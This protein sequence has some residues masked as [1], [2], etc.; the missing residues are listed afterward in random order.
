MPAQIVA[1]P[2][3]DVKALATWLGV[4]PSEGMFCWQLRVGVDVA[5][6]VLA[7]EVEELVAEL[8]DPLVVADRLC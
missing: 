2:L 3:A 6:D 1:I 4:G 8:M 7:L 5:L